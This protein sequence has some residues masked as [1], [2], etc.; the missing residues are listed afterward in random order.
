[1][2]GTDA[3]YSQLGW[4]VETARAATDANGNATFAWPAG[5][6][7]GPPVVALAVEAGAGFRSARIAANSATSTTV[8]VLQSAGVTVLGIGVLAVGTP[9]VGVTVHATATAP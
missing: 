3:S 9:A 4:R 6:F 8:S 5:V 1:M 2:A 7:S